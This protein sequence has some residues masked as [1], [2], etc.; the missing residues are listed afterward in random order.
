M[1]EGILTLSLLL[2]LAG[3][4]KTNQQVVPKIVP[5]VQQPS[6]PKPVAKK[7]MPAPP[8]KEIKL[9]EVDDTNF[10]PEYMY[11][12]D[13]KD[14]LK[15]VGSTETPVATTLTQSMGKE[16][17]IAMITQEKFDKYTAMFGSEDASIKRCKML[18]AMQ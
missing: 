12:D 11:P 9:K 2:L 16:E 3:C 7:P 4:T 8:K 6:T 1:R 17:C 14:Q 18:K 15:A 13:K 10:N 5:P